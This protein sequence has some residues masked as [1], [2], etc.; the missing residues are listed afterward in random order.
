MIIIDEIDSVGIKTF[1]GTPHDSNEAANGILTMI[2]KIREE[3]L[4]I[5]IIGTTNY[6]SKLDAAIMR[7]GRFG[8]QIEFTHPSSDKI[9]EMVE[10]LKLQTE[11]QKL[12][13]F[14]IS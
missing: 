7:S 8:W 1:S 4:N 13:S 5:I 12:D 11:T 14:L 2:D 3:E 6:S 9:V 10:Q